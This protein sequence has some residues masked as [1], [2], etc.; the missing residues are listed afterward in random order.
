M[1]IGEIRENTAQ[2]A[3]KDKESINTPTKEENATES[4]ILSERDIHGFDIKGL[5]ANKA[6]QEARIKTSQLQADITKGVQSGE[7]IYIL[8][9][10][11][12]EALAISTRNEAFYTQIFESVRAVRGQGLLEET[13]LKIEREEIQ[14]RLSRLVKSLDRPALPPETQHSIENAIR[15][16]VALLDELEKIINQ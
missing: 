5:K 3:R 6:Y 8:F 10:K 4:E 14:K 7:D 16:H 11:A 13:P 12:C 9:L 2:N 15:S 1:E